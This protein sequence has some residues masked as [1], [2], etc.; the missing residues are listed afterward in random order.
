MKTTL[1]NKASQVLQTAYHNSKPQI[2]IEIFTIISIITAIIGIIQRCSD[3]NNI[4]TMSKK[5]T[6]KSKWIIRRIVKKHLTPAQYRTESD[7][8]ISGLFATGSTSSIEEIQQMIQEMK[9]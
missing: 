9:E 7:K 6:I 1:S 3:T 4:P 8:I 5:P 2:V